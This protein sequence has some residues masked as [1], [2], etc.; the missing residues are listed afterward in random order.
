MKQRQFETAG[1]RTREMFWIH[2]T[3]WPRVHPAH[4]WPRGLAGLVGI[5]Q[6][7][8]LELECEPAVP[9][10]RVLGLAG[11]RGESCATKETHSDRESERDGERRRE[12]ERTSTRRTERDGETARKRVSRQSDK[13]KASESGGSWRGRKQAASRQPGKPSGRGEADWQADKQ[14]SK[15][16]GRQVDRQEQEDNH[17]ASQPPPVVACHP[18][19]SPPTLDHRLIHPS[20]PLVLRTTPTLSPVLSAASFVRFVPLLRVPVVVVVVVRRVR[21][22]QWISPVVYLPMLRHFYRRGSRVSL[23]VRCAEGYRRT[24]DSVAWSRQVTSSGNALT[25]LSSPRSL[26]P[27]FLPLFSRVSKQHSGGRGWFV[28][29]R[30]GSNTPGEKERNRERGRA[31]LESK[32]EGIHTHFV[33]DFSFGDSSEFWRFF[34]LL[35]RGKW[36]RIWEVWNLGETR[37]DERMR[38]GATTPRR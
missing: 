22:V 5:E 33:R 10:R 19:R 2:V 4:H 6:L 30:G 20:S 1:V 15:Q 18:N 23:A 21:R 37:R 29:S 9:I 27:P 38:W 26:S 11:S 28:G 24:F 36:G 32:I 8:W 12:R 7:G 17:R 34:Y 13:S 16:A 35:V 25:C 3:T 31:S 14:A